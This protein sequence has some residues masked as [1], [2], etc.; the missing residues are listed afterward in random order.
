M[1]RR[2]WALLATFLALLVLP[3]LLHAQVAEPKRTPFGITAPAGDGSRALTAGRPAAS[4]PAS[5][6]PPG[7]LDRAWGWVL[8]QQQAFRKEMNA[9]VQRLKEEPFGSAFLLIVF[10]SFAYGVLHAVGPGHGKGVISGY[11]LA[12][13]QAVRRGVLLSFM[14]AL[15]QALSA[16]SIFAV[17][18]L[19]LNAKK[20]D[21]DTVESWLST[22]SWG[23]VALI[24]A[25]LTWRQIR[26]LLTA[27]FERLAV[28]PAHAH[29]HGH[30]PA[31]GHSM[32]R[33][34]ALAHGPAA[35]HHH[36]RPSHE[37]GP[38]SGCG[39]S[40]I[41]AARDLEGQW[42]L[43]RA[44]AIAFSVGI[45]PCTGALGVLAV[46][47]LNGLFWVGVAATLAMGIGTAITTSVIAATAAG[48]RDLA[49]RFAGE[50]PWAGRIASAASFA[51]ATALLVLGT[52][53]FFASLWGG[54]API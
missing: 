6:A 5:V 10:A 36:G 22:A 16:I 14:A 37:H 27:T 30:L 33:E 11:V 1:I 18:N 12:N 34:H 45:R 20:Q 4:G 17:L 32:A 47:T 2:I 41:P 38:D 53:F 42:S 46:T 21:F 7:V 49:L 24:G 3:S 39:H 44:V 28:A 23:L 9:A 50:G 35:H 31:H 26:P 40:H 8:V 19:A 13:N 15:I 54:G 29:V 25:W 51:G 52:V 43:S 48:S